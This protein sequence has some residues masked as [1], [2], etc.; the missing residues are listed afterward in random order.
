MG[1]SQ[2][3]VRGKVRETLRKPGQR[4]RGLGAKFS[5]FAGDILACEP[6]Q[7]C[8]RKLKNKFSHSVGAKAS[9]NPQKQVGCTKKH[10]SVRLKQGL[11]FVLKTRLSPSLSFP[12]G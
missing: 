12:L 3:K 10:K 8:S 11:N 2:G 5:L 7:S 9:E 4:L 6:D 1:K